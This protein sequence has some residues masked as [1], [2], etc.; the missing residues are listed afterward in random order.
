VCDRVPGPTVLTHF[1]ISAQ[2]PQ[3]P[4]RVYEFCTFVQHKDLGLGFAS[5]S[6]LFGG[7]FPLSFIR[8]G[9]LTVITPQTF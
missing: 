8:K 7:K 5:V 4:L 9:M 2:I 3:I 1:N 6:L